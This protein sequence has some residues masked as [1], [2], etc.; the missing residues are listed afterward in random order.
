MQNARTILFFSTALVMACAAPPETDVTVPNGSHTQTPADKLVNP[1]EPMQLGQTPSDA[2]ESQEKALWWVN[3]FR[4]RAGLGPLDEKSSLNNAAQAH[5]SY[6]LHNADLYDNKQ[7]SVHEEMSDRPGFTGV[8]FWERM[9]HAQYAS[10]AFREVIAYQAHP[11]G[12]V[13]HWMETVYHRLP[14]LHP[15]ARHMGYAQLTNG[16]SQ[17]NVLDMGTGNV[18]PL[19]IP[20]GVAW[21]PP[22]ARD[23]S[24]SWDGLESPQPPA[25]AGGYPSG[26]VITLTF[27]PIKLIEITHH[28]IVDLDQNSA[29]LAHVLLTP[30][31]DPNLHGESSIALYTNNPLSPGHS[32]QVTIEG[33]VDDHHFKRSWRFTTRAN[34]GC[35][36]LAQDCEVGKACYG[37]SDDQSICAW[38]GGT[39]EGDAC[40]YQNDCG[41]GLTC[42]GKMCR[43]YCWY[44]PNDQDG[45]ASECA[46]EYSPLNVEAE[47]GVCKG[48]PE[49]QL[50]FN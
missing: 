29:A 13:A 20:D 49:R 34:V 11:A 39:N 6:V 3:T 26:P 19:T 5:A 9:E 15:S 2:T 44:S 37:S 22:N 47:I 41:R 25:P 50:A 28:K 27:P 18:D 42:I 43:R 48:N 17:I 45:C 24:L 14:L 35:S 10:N 16:D 1:H 31:N 30:N 38:E 8:R 21:P 7:L 46:A 4:A 36:L 40:S 12:A 32:Y 33:I 23:V